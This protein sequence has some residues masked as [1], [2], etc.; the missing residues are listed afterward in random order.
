MNRILEQHVV[1]SHN[2]NEWQK[3]SENK[4]LRPAHERMNPM[5][6]KTTFRW[7]L[8]VV[9]DA[10]STDRERDQKAKRIDVMA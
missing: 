6:S 8:S 5:K 4:P 7:E 3:E 1:N 9:P 10:D 2:G